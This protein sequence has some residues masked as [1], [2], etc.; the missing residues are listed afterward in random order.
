MAEKREKKTATYP[1]RNLALQGGGVKAFAY[2]GVL[3]VLEE[4]DILP[5]I[6]RVVGTSA[7]AML[8]ALLSF[9]LSVE[10]T[11]DLFNSADFSRVPMATAKTEE[12]PAEP[13]SVIRRELDRVMVG[14]NAVGRLVRQYG[15]YA[16]DY[17]HQWLQEA[18]GA[19]CQGNGRATF[20][21]FRERGFRDVHVVAANISTHTT[22]V[23][24]AATTPDVA[25][26]DAVLMSAS[27]PLYFEG[28]RFDGASLGQGDYY[29]DGGILCNFPLRVFDDPGFEEGN[30][31]YVHGVNWE[32]LGCR[33]YTPEDCPPR[34]RPISNVISYVENLLETLT[35][36]EVVAF[37]SSVVDQLRTISISNCCVA[38]TD[39]HVRPADAKYDELVD[40]GRTAARHYLANYRLPTAKF[41]KAKARLARF[42]ARWRQAN[43]SSG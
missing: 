38:A 31:R 27:V 15:W 13:P 37:E 1:F 30:R 33:L 14:V 40:A 28:L 18:I 22:T 23:F 24:S 2:H 9:R 3:E 7:G 41:Q 5:Q 34:T 12:L 11:I 21:D 36:A 19:H 39:F 16:N 20:A 25:V 26:A 35:E 8:A 43:S 6:E 42:L 32:T 10:E 4:H 29:A 17:L